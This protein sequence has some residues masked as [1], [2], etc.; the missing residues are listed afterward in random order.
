MEFTFS[1]KLSDDPSEVNTLKRM[2]FA[3]DLCAVLW[4]LTFGKDTPEEVSKKVWDTLDSHGID[5][6][7]IYN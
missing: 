5:L 4:E 1:V 6:E 7:S 3:D 2:L